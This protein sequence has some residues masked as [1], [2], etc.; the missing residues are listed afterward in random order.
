MFGTQSVSNLN[1]QEIVSASAVQSA[2][3]IIF[4]LLAL[5]VIGGFLLVKYLQGFKQ[6][7]LKRKG[8]GLVFFEVKLPNSN[9]VE[10]RAAEQMYTGLL[11][12]GEELKGFKSF[13]GARKFVSFEIVAF[14][15]SIKFYVVCPKS[16][17]NIVDR[18]INSTY[19]QAEINQVK[20]YNLFP[21]AAYASYAALKLDKDT[22]IPFQTYEELAVDS[23]GALTDIFSKLRDNEG[24]VFQMI[25]SPAGSKWR[26]EAKDFVKKLRE[27]AK[28]GEKASKPK[29]DDDTISLMDKKADKSGF[30][31]DV[32]IVCISDTKF[33]ADSSLANS[34]SL[35]DQ[36]LKE[37]GNKFKKMKDKEVG[38]I[39][40]D[41]IYRIP[42]QS[43]I[44]NTAELA[45]L[46]HFPNKNVE[47]PHIKWLLAKKAP[48]PDFVA[49]T[50]QKDYMY[51]GR[52]SFRGQFKEIF[53]KP[54]DRLRHFYV[55]GQTGTGKS[56]FMSGMMIRDMK[57]GHGCGYIDPHGTDA[58]KLLQQIPPERV[59]DVVIFDPSDLERPV[60]LNMLEF[61]NP[62]QRTLVTNEML[63]IFDTLYNLKVTGGPMFEQYFRYAI[64][65]LTDD[66][67]S[68]S[69][70]MEI[71]KIFADDGYR[72][73]KLSKCT[74]QEVIDFWRKQAEQATGDVGLKNVTPYVVSKLAPF[75][76]NQY[77]RPIIAQQESTINFRKIMDEGKI[78]IVK[79]TKGKIGE[80]NA[81]LLGMIIV[82][83]FLV[84]ALEREGTD[85][86]SRNPFYLYID[87]F[88]NYL[89]D[90][91]K[92]ILSEA[93][94]YRLAL[95]LGHQYVGQL[96]REGNNTSIKDAVFGNVG[97]K[98]VF[99]VGADDSI[100]LSKEMGETVDESDLQQIENFNFYF[101][102]LADGK[103]T[104]AFTTRSFYG[105][106]PYDMI[107]QPNPQIADVAKQISR[108]KYG[109]DR[110]IIENE[111]KLRGTF[112]KEKTEEEKKPASLFGGGL[113][114]F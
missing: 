46:F 76:T 66:I 19:P 59:E 67:E 14:K 87:E 22:R 4:V 53:I 39:A 5:A 37:G 28:E 104:P 2:A 17:A 10:I 31:T 21:D 112:I 38:T 43:M 77:V 33:S 51:V 41:V 101:R 105:D 49:S 100:F 97:N 8:L 107:G 9:D 114:G 36:F 16:I 32:R 7:V 71:P 58:E 47:A 81:A 55:I 91:I 48:A 69:T 34:L 109:K 94:K 96:V 78:L 89:T 11:G 111:I 3:A 85:E 72:N 29:F 68:G 64:M 13:I 103:P 98:A 57:L 102:M 113:G 26:N 54:E 12:I 70:L 24:A 15:E 110:N 40:E 74:D 82:G 99:R 95:T 90:G 35:F 30:Y 56:A 50:Y 93:R 83:K 18:Q 65:L 106:S 88:Q 60:G 25:I 27:P 52:N 86:K 79:L 1:T 20:E 92:V 63:N 108:L 75:L 42:R 6:A 61:S 80:L 45:T 62:A 44:L 23:V 73:Y 84:A